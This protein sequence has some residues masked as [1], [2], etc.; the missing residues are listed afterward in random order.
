MTGILIIVG[1]VVA[2]AIGGFLLH[3][4]FHRFGRSK[5]RAMESHPAPPGRVGRTSEFRRDG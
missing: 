3:A 1:I 2:V 5:Q 4:A